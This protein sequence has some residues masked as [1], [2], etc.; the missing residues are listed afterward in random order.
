[1]SETEEA[2]LYHNWRSHPLGLILGE[3]QPWGDIF[4]TS[5]M[6]VKTTPKK[7]TTENLHH[8]L[9]VGVFFWYFK[10]HICFFVLNGMNL[11]LLWLNFF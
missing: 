7:N 6:T 8:I 1:M 11:N 10:N 5:S 9:L 3:L 2:H 4:R